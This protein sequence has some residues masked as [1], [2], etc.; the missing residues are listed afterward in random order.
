MIAIIDACG[1][2]FAS[3]EFA[4][5]RLGRAVTLT[6]DKDII[7]SASH[8]ILPGVGTASQ[9]M[10]QLENLQLISVIQQLTQPVLGICLGMQILHA[11]SAEGD[12]DCLGLLPGDI[13]PLPED[14]GLPIPHM[15]W[16]QLCISHATSS[17]LQDIPNNSYVYY[18]HSYAAPV[19]EHTLATTQYGAIFTAAVHYKNFYG[20]QFHP[21]RSGAVGAKILQNFLVLSES[22][23]SP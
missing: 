20:V 23:G 2:N 9:A 21:E 12:V 10:Q 11:H 5:K 15:G 7:R 16:N 4:L 14:Q 19:T 6:R 8:V 18:V 17:L 22:E 3:V 1:A 13:K